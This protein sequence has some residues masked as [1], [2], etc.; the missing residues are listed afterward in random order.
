MDYTKFQQTFCSQFLYLM[1]ITHEKSTQ[2]DLTFLNISTMTLICE[3]NKNVNLEKF[4]KNYESIYF[5]AILKKNKRNENVTVTKRGKVKKSFFNQATLT[6][7]DTTTKSIKIFSNGKLQMT[8]I[9]SLIEGIDIAIK[10]KD[11]IYRFTQDTIDIK[12]INVAMINSNFAFNH[13]INLTQLNDSLPSSIYEPDTYPGV[14][15]KKHDFSIFVFGT[16]NVVITGGNSLSQL[17]KAYTYIIENIKPHMLGKRVEHKI[18]KMKECVDGYQ[19]NMLDC[20]IVKNF[21]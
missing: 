11:I 13:T 2:S 17:E 4:C 16:G 1:Q 15:L 9:P 20:C 14:K 10:I 3:L 21:L 6:F 19:K 18:K 7:K 12:N 8:G 5:N